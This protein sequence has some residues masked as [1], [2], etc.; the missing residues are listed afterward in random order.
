LSWVMLGG[1]CRHCKNPISV[2]YTLVELM[3][4]ALFLL[5]G[6]RALYGGSEANWTQAAGFAIEAWLI[7]A[8]IVCTFI[9]LEVRI[10]P[11]EVTLS[12]IVI[13]LAASAAFPF[14]HGWTPPVGPY[15]WDA[16]HGLPCEIHEPH[17][18]SLLAGVAGL[19][20]GGGSIWL[21]GVLGKLV[22]RKE[23]MGF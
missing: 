19:I 1:K 23:A 15:R 16:G 10:L 9:E 3:T 6:R 8:M 20:A 5:A 14:L 22:F 21:V 11:A 2:R 12:G 7:S 13:G 18:A 17:A 4:G